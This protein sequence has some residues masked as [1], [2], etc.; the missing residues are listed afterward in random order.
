MESERSYLSGYYAP[1]EEKIGQ[2]P[3]VVEERRD[4]SFSGKINR[5]IHELQIELIELE[6]LKSIVASNPIIYTVLASKQGKRISRF[7]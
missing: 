3:K 1:K 6:A 5:R 2:I 7:L 4:N